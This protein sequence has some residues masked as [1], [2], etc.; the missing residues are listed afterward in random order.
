MLFSRWGAFVYRFRRPIALLTVVLAIASLTLASRVT[1]ALSSGGW[2]D[3]HSDSAAVAT[4]LADEFG[5]GRGSIVA[6]FQGDSATD[7]RSAAF[8]QTI[9]TSL[10]RL[11]ADPIADGVIGFASTRDPRFVSTD[12]HS[13]YAVV[14][15]TVT[16][17][18]SANEMPRIRS[19][20]DPPAGATLKLAG[21][22]PFTQDQARQSEKELVQAETISGPFALLILLAVQNDL[23]SQ[24]TD[25]SGVAVLRYPSGAY[26]GGG[27][28]AWEAW[29]L[30][31]QNVGLV[32]GDDR[33]DSDDNGRR[34]DLYRPKVYV[35]EPWA[36]GYGTDGGRMAGLFG[37]NTFSRVVG[38]YALPKFTAGS[39]AI[40]SS[41]AFRVFASLA[42][43]TALGFGALSL[44]SGVWKWAPDGS[45]NFGAAVF[46]STFLP[47][48]YRYYTLRLKSDTPGVSIRIS[49]RLWR[50]HDAHFGDLYATASWIVT[51][52]TGGYEDHELDWLFPDELEDQ[53]LA[54]S[55]APVSQRYPFHPYFSQARYQATGEAIALTLVLPPHVTLHV[56]SLTGHQRS[57]G[58]RTA[59]TLHAPLP[60]WTAGQPETAM[61]PFTGVSGT[62]NWGWLQ[63]NAALGMFLQPA[64][65]YVAFPVAATMQDGI[66]NL[67]G[68]YDDAAR[69]TGL[70]LADAAAPLAAR[71]PWGP[72]TFLVQDGV[73]L[74]RGPADA[75]STDI[76]GVRRQPGCYGYYGMG[77]S[78]EN[79]AYGATL[80][81]QG[82]LWLDG[83]LTALAWKP[84]ASVAGVSIEL[85]DN[86]TG[87]VL[88]TAATDADGLFAVSSKY[89]VREPFSS[90]P[91]ADQSLAAHRQFTDHGFLPPDY[92]TPGKLLNS[93]WLSGL[94]RFRERPGDF[95]EYSPTQQFQHNLAPY[96]I[97]AEVWTGQPHH[98]D[99]AIGSPSRNPDNL[100]DPLG[101]F[102]RASIGD[103][104]AGDTLVYRRMDYNTPEG[105][106]WAVET[107]VGPGATDPSMAI[108]AHDLQLRISLSYTRAGGAPGIYERTSD[109]DGDTFE[110][111][112]LVIPNGTRSRNF[113]GHPYTPERFL[114]AV[115]PGSPNTIQAVYKG[116]GDAA[117]SGVFT[118]K[119]Q[120]GADLEV[121]DD[122]FDLSI[123]TEPG[124]G[125]V[126]WTLS[127]VISGE[128]EVSEWYSDS[129]PDF[130]SP[131]MRW[132]RVI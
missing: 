63:V 58:G 35:S 100:T 96:R 59:M 105:G 4:R 76:V 51:P 111:E 38:L 92:T 47:L 3:P 102:H 129:E 20:I 12:G 32:V 66:S 44:D 29:S 2:M 57:D 86:D 81:Y 48:A 1:G 13:A 94:F 11:A 70:T 33:S 106:G 82:D 23:D 49:A 75:A 115:V 34:L 45:D 10:G 120:A 41:H 77:A 103:L 7:A 30:A 101:R 27:L 84:R 64:P 121:E 55:P 26:Y 6:L 117:W 40:A 22:G 65:G 14:R 68:L 73:T 124:S 88:D 132:E 52:A 17:E 109:D 113:T 93:Y 97:D 108:D 50:F 118:L 16:D 131:E 19:L 128:T 78:Y 5:A 114:A 110:P 18:Q 9:A 104:G 83:E 37:P 80:K 130:A 116:P 71:N 36:D 46:A 112:A 25:G 54:T 125:L 126:R 31:V 53:V 98:Y 74:P 85:V 24:A 99:L 119:D 67:R 28:T 60:E 56:E 87:A 43:W 122:N 95:A 61:K 21:V 42:G 15:L 107:D 79:G 69:D 72:Q 8:Q 91:A 62:L 89:G 127:A 123:G 90:A 39:L